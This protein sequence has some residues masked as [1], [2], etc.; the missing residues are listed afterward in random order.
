MGEVGE[1]GAKAS[2]GACEVVVVAL[3]KEGQKVLR[4]LN[5]QKTQGV[6]AAVV[7]AAVVVA[8]V[9]G[10]LAELEAVTAAGCGE[11]VIEGGRKQFCCWYRCSCCQQEWRYDFGC[12]SC[13]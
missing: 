9:A 2:G 5:E 7:A 8:V 12:C 3:G 10:D 1:V 11:G 13:E 4:A 6:A